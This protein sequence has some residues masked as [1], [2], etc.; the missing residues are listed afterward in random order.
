MVNIDKL[1][2]DVLCGP[3]CETL[4][5]TNRWSYSCNNEATH[6]RPNDLCSLI[7][8]IREMISTPYRNLR[9]SELG[10]YEAYPNADDVDADDVDLDQLKKAKFCPEQLCPNDGKFKFG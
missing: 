6:V 2:P 8:K 4:P 7:C 9:C 5:S 3:F 1:D 10:M